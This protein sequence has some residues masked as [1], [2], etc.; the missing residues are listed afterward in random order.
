MREHGSLEAAFQVHAPD[1][2]GPASI[3]PMLGGFHRAFMAQTGVSPRTKKHVANPEAG[4][5]AKR[6]NMFLRWMVRPSPEGWTWELWSSFKPQDLHIPL[7]V[8]TGN[9]GRKLGLLTRKAND[10]RAVRI[11][12]VFA[13]D[14]SPGPG[15]AGFCAVWVGGDGRILTFA[16]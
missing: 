6:L 5:A 7:D 8:H 16:R 13:G 14:G 12:G 9:V 4:S 15:P 10:W 3:K 1:G 2:E 11:D